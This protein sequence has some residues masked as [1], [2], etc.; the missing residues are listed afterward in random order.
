MS[1]AIV[2]SDICVWSV[3]VNDGLDACLDNLLVVGE[4]Q[5]DGFSI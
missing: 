5:E 4:G 2:A 1:D 3:V